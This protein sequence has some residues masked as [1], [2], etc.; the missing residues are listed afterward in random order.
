MGPWVI[1]LI[2]LGIGLVLTFLLRRNTVV[3]PQVSDWQQPESQIQA[4]ASCSASAAR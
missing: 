3:R 1:L 2:G 4:A